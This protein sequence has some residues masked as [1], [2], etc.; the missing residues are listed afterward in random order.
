MN[1]NEVEVKR[2]VERMEN[3][4]WDVHQ[5][6]SFGTIVSYYSYEK[7]SKV[8]TGLV[9]LVEKLQNNLELQE[10]VI[11]YAFNGYDF[12]EFRE[13]L[14]GIIEGTAFTTAHP[15]CRFEAM[16]RVVKNQ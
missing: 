15:K 5:D 8:Y 10:Q 11:E 4:H 13:N 7:G 14:K 3:E 16:C 2:L 12:S 9:H 1:N 6:S